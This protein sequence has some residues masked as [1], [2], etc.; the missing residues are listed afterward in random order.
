MKA[1]RVLYRD[2][3]DDGLVENYVSLKVLAHNAAQLRSRRLGQLLRDLD[4][5]VGLA[6]K[7]G[8][9]LPV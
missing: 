9:R 8:L 1:P 6:R 7:R 2:L 3:T 4:I 5:V